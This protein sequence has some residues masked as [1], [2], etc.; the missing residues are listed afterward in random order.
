MFFDLE[1]KKVG[2]STVP[3]PVIDADKCTMCGKCSENCAFHAL[4]KM[5][6]TILVYEKMCHGCGLCMEICP[7]GAIT[8]KEREIGYIYSG[9]KECLLFHYGELIV[10]EELTTMVISTLKEYVDKTYPT[11]IIDA[12][13]GSSCPMVETVAGS[14]YVIIVSEPTPFGLSDMKIVVKTL[15]ILEKK[16]GVIIN[17]DGIGNADLEQYCKNEEIPI[18]M[19][20]PFDF[21]IAKRYSEGETLVKSFPKW[22][23]QFRDVIQKIG[24]MI[25]HE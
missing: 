21:E 19:K 24:E 2:N 1:N 5:P 13:P 10:G 11:I 22:K 8:E 14:D 15:R 4:G 3:I 7:E 18:L 16:F 6:D 25:E 23:K 9:K 20:I 12:P 17:K